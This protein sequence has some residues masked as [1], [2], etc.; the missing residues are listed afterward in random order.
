MKTTLLTGILI[1]AVGC[2]VAFASDKDVKD[3]KDTKAS[4]VATKEKEKDKAQQTT[5]PRQEKVAL[6]GSYIKRDVRRN[7]Q[8]TDGPS[9]VAVIDNKTIQN[10]GAADLRQLLNRQGVSH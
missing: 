7:G 1:L 3:A 8:I 2:S 5:A 6:T 10:S 9:P 4:T